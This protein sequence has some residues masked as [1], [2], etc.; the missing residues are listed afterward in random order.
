LQLQ[1]TKSFAFFLSFGINACASLSY[2]SKPTR[3]HCFLRCTIA[4]LQVIL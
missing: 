3:P 2:F 4:S 1:I